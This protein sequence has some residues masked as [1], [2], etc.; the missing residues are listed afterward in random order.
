MVAVLSLDPDPK[1][2]QGN[3][4]LRLVN[5]IVVDIK[6]SLGGPYW[7][8]PF[9]DM[10]RYALEPLQASRTAVSLESFTKNGRVSKF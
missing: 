7:F 5:R 10:V 6:L 3:V 8:L 4:V 2:P 9:M 1:I